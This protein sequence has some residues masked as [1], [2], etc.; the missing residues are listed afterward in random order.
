MDSAAAPIVGWYGKLPSL[1]D[2]ASRRLPA[3]FIEA[4]DDWLANGL[5]AWRERAPDSWLD[6]YLA[7]PS[8]RFVLMPGALPDVAPGTVPGAAAIWSGVLMPSV[9]RVGRYFPLT[10]AQPLAQLPLDATQTGALLSW[11]QRLDDLAV[12]ALQDD[13]SV[14]QLESELQR[15]G[16]CPQ[17]SPAA[18]DLAPAQITQ[19]SLELH[20]SGGVAELLAGLA[21]GQLLQQLQG[22]ALWLSCDGQGRPVLRITSGLP[23]ALDFST[24]MTRAADAAPASSPLPP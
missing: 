15:L 6:D 19:A 16:P 1:G 13:W 5:L 8:W 20:P 17:H 12:D 11:L 3:E 10:L 23:Q 24:L 4:W 9:D 21:R 14:E 22:K 7:G 2:F 18:Q